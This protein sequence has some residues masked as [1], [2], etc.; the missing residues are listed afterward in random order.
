MGSIV[1]F[2]PALCYTAGTLYKLRI[3]RVQR[4]N[5]S[6]VPVPG[7]MFSSQ[8]DSE[9]MGKRESESTRHLS[10]CSPCL[11]HFN[12]NSIA[13][14]FP[15]FH[16]ARSHKH[17]HTDI[18][19]YAYIQISLFTPIC[20]HNESAVYLLP[21]VCMSICSWLWISLVKT[22]FSRIFRSEI[23]LPLLPTH[24]STAQQTPRQHDATSATTSCAQQSIST[25][26]V[27]YN[28]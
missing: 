15:L 3:R 11:G 4:S 14:V 27:S 5:W 6:R 22:A 18:E 24:S 7:Q 21:P 9:S 23:A 13:F 10:F 19:I 8:P 1:V 28:H 12:I 2:S 26:F 20:A 17:M 25:C 16:S